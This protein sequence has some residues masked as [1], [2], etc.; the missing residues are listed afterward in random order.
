MKISPIQSKDL[1]KNLNVL[2]DE[3]LKS[4]Q[5][6]TDADQL[7]IIV[8]KGNIAHSAT[9]NLCNHE[10]IGL[11]LDTIEKASKGLECDCEEGE[12]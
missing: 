9:Y 1:A 6:M 2:S 10:V 8:M 11:S 12:T 5:Q 3:K 7:L 4:I